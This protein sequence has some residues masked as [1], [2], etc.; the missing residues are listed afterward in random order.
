MNNIKPGFIILLILFAPALADAQNRMP[1][2]V[3][4]TQQYAWRI[5][6][7]NTAPLVTAFDAD[8]AFSIVQIPGYVR[9]VER[10]MPALPFKRFWFHIPEGMTVTAALKNAAGNMLPGRLKT[11]ES[12][13]APLPPDA[14]PGTQGYVRDAG[15]KIKD[16]VLQ[17]AI[18]VLPAQYNPA[19]GTLRWFET[20]TLDLSFHP[21]R[22]ANKAA[23]QS[24]PDLQERLEAF[25]QNTLKYTRWYTPG[26]Q[27]LRI[28]TLREGLYRLTPSDLS[29][30]NVPITGIDPATFQIIA[31]GKEIPIVVTGAQDGSF[32]GADYLQFYAPR[33]KGIHGEYFDEWSDENVLWLRWGGSTGLRAGTENADPS[34]GAPIANVPTV[35]HLEEDHF[36][37]IGDSEIQDG[38]ISAKVYGEGWV[39]KYLLKDSSFTI[40]CTIAPNTSAQAFLVSKVKLASV[41]GCLVEVL[42]NGQKLKQFEVNR[43]PGYPIVYDTIAIPAGTLKNGANTIT[44][45]SAGLRPCPPDTL[46][47]IE[48]FYLD[49]A[50]LYYYSEPASGGAQVL[51]NPRA[52]DLLPTGNARERVQLTG[53]PAERIHM[54]NT[55][56]GDTLAMAESA[57]AGSTKSVS[58]A[59]APGGRY[60]AA[61]ESAINVPTSLRLVA[62]PDFISSSNAADYLVV[63]HRDFRPAAERLASYRQSSDDYRTF[64]AEVDD[65]Y[66]A[67]NFG[68]K[69]PDAIRRFTMM[70][71]GVWQQ[72]APSFLTILGDAS[73]DPKWLSAFSNKTDF[74]PTY[75]NPVSDEYLVSLDS[76][77]VLPLLRNGRIPCETLEAANAVLDKIIEYEA[78]PPQD[79]HN[80]ILFT[81]GGK[82]AFELTTFRN[83]SEYQIREFVLPF[84]LEP[85]RIY[86]N[87]YKLVSYDDIDSITAAL[88]RGVLWF[89]FIG[90]GGTRII[91]I[92]IERPD[93]FAM[94]G[95]Y[96]VFTTMSCNTAHYGEPAETGLNE[97]FIMSERNGSIISLGTSGLGYFSYDN[98]L[99]DKMFSSFVIDSMRTYGDVLRYAKTA[100]LEEFDVSTN[101]IVRNLVMQYVLLGDPATKLPLVHI[102]ELGI[103]AEDIVSNES[104]LLEGSTAEFSTLIHNYR[105]CLQD[106]VDVEFTAAGEDGVFFTKEV[107]IP[108]FTDAYSI[109]WPL[110]LINVTGTIRI[111]VTIDKNMSLQESTRA[112]N[113]ATIQKAVLAR[114]VTPVFPRNNAG[115]PAGSPGFVVSNPS[116]VPEDNGNVEIELEID[117]TFAFGNPL[118]RRG[119]EIGK[120]F[121]WFEDIAL[122][123]DRLYFWRSRM[124]VGNQPD[125]WSAVSTAFVGSSTGGERWLQTGAK[126]FSGASLKNT[127]VR[128]EGSIVLDSRSVE[129]ELLSAGNNN[130]EINNLAQIFVDNIDYAPNAR[131]FNIAVIEPVAGRVTD[132]ASFDTYRGVAN[133]AA[134]VSYLRTIPDDH[135]CALA[136][137]D[138][139]NGYWGLDSTRTNITAELRS[140]LNRFGASLIDTALMKFKY[141]MF[142]DSYAMFGRR[143][144][145]EKTKE[146]FNKYGATFFKDTIS[147]RA[148]SGS[149]RSGLIGPGSEWNQFEWS[150]SLPSPA[151]RFTLNVWMPRTNGDSLLLTF[152]D[153][154]PGKPVSL[155]GIGQNV[156]FISVE[157][158]LS[159]STAQNSPVIDSWQVDYASQFPELGI[160]SQVVSTDRDSVLQG[161][162]VMLTYR[163]YNA[164]RTAAANVPVYIRSDRQNAQQSPVAVIPAIPP[165]KDQYVEIEYPIS[166][167]DRTGKW[168]AEIAV[169][170]FQTGTEYNLY[171]NNYSKT[172]ITSGDNQRPDLQVTF[173]GI[174][175][176]DFDYVSPAPR[177]DISLR[178]NSPLPFTDT[179]NVQLFLDGRRIWLNN[180]PQIQYTFGGSGEEKMHIVYTPALNS[181]IRNLAVSARDAGG[182]AADTIPYQ[183]TFFVSSKNS[184]DQVFP[185]PNPGSGPVNFTFRI[186]GASIPD[187]GSVKIYSI[188][189][190]L[191]RELEIPKGSLHIGFNTVEWDGKDQDGDILANGAYL[192]KIAVQRDG[193]NEEFTGKIA[194]LR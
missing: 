100:L 108:P 9:Q 120:V 107:R 31:D 30:A 65:I 152:P 150:G 133:T 156:R 92:G 22:N 96:P 33:M 112:N 21:L 176:V 119:K 63:T 147:V 20:G 14:L 57:T 124:V 83:Q 179:S 41:D 60:L 185:V 182:I 44:Y 143:L 125:A 110:P 141:T 23:I 129:V 37:H 139:A 71:I 132:T 38:N 93:I 6:F 169:D 180:N 115:L 54:V 146:S 149:A 17:R 167:L 102:P 187:G 170:P 181:G 142:H 16:G 104:Q 19:A 188:A 40:G 177:I 166:T 82:D 138:D 97:K 91:D 88:N 8:S 153:L 155:S 53:F 67:Y 10:G 171:N 55:V 144:E 7:D 157:A 131:G 94:Q 43:D 140:E 89:N 186:I 121:T 13:A 25:N 154:G 98:F 26:E 190:R 126:Q 81:A 74:V 106:S 4:Q 193:K 2:A 32:D 194:V 164:G 66:N 136:I 61:P 18:D 80:R 76:L 56:T 191:L 62:M 24:I 35:L 159:D 128:Q 165:G 45:H 158:L 68:H 130:G 70:A 114:S 1:Y 29:A 27:L 72:P 103:G 5:A 189:G 109:A 105:F 145:P 135:Y 168:N 192:Y 175:I 78:I 113:T 86:K 84:C 148:T 174:H 39:W 75:G 3:T 178:D 73:W 51:L 172:L 77:E 101:I 137:R 184:I 59:F 87:D 173:D 12:F 163:V 42:V 49:W 162:P 15:Y 111:T 122:S 58:F 118:I 46:C 134:L 50:E 36:Y 48:R 151:S 123:G 85:Q 99:S 47:S 64:V 52:R 160:N 28:S 34:T 116:V 79:W 90:H 95:K 11:F 183:V 117:T 69:S 127:A 161:E